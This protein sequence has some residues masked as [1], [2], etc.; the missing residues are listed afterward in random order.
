VE[1]T[2][3]AV[4][5]RRAGDAVPELHRDPSIWSLVAANF[6][7]LALALALQ[8]SAASLMLVYWAQ[9]IMIG[10]SYML[11]I[12][13]LERFST[14]DFKINDSPVEPTPE[15]K[16]KVGLF[17]AFHYGFF[18]FAYIVFLT[19]MAREPLLDLGFFIC[20]LVLAINHLWSYR[21]NRELDR[22]GTPNIGTMMFTPYLRILPMH[23]TIIFGAA[24]SDSRASLLLFGVLKT[25]AD[26]AMHVVEHR[27]LQKIKM[28]GEN[29]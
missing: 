10:V 22:Q 3:L 19:T 11:R 25:A 14:K 12:F 15:T 1:R 16:R 28:G 6:L 2:K 8:W 13:S 7:T 5:P 18:H 9:S 17:F 20:V 29:N 24:I 4:A 23:F 27:Q 26:V 21:Y